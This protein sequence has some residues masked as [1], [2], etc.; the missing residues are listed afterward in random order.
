MSPLH[1]TQFSTD[2]HIH[3]FISARISRETFSTESFS[4]DWNLLLIQSR[5]IITTINKLNHNS[6]LTI[7]RLTAPPIRPTEKKNGQ[8][9]LS[10]TLLGLSIET[11]R[12]PPISGHFRFLTYSSRPTTFKISRPKK[13]RVAPLVLTCKVHVFQKYHK[14]WATRAAFRAISCQTF[15]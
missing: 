10:S 4:S 2:N 8:D 5:L 14:K 12:L 3:V 15:A 1:L 13:K 11:D 6:A 7:D 9:D